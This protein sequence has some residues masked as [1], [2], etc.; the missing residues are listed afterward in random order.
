M[1]R[2]GRVTILAI[3]TVAPAVLAADEATDLVW[4]RDTAVAW[5]ATQATGRPLL[6]FVVSDHCPYCKLM[7]RNTFSDRGVLS[8]MRSTV[9]AARVHAA[10]QPELVRELRIQAY[11]TTV[12]V[13]KESRV[14]GAIPGYVEPREFERLLRQAAAQLT[15]NEAA[16]AKVNLEAALE[17]RPEHA[18]ALWLL[19]W[20]ELQQGDRKNARIHLEAALEKKPGSEGAAQLLAILDRQEG[21]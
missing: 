6:L 15:Q 1:F 13:S 7:E 20:A 10:E 18:E 19:G 11:P 4:R 3:A 9:I 17:I 5:Q 2:I 14:L 16:A 12:L 8:R 21:R